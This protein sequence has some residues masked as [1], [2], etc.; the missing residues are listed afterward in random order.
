MTFKDSWKSL[1]NW[2]GENMKRNQQKVSRGFSWF[3]VVIISNLITPITAWL[4]GGFA[5]WKTYAIIC[6]VAGISFAIMLIE[7]VFGTKEKP[8]VI[9]PVAPEPIVVEPM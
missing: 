7:S 2:W 3:L 1:V 6:V 9:A 4:S 8:D 5:D